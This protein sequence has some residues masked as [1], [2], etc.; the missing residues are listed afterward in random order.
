MLLISSSF[1]ETFA[2]PII[3]V[4]GLSDSFNALVKASISCC[5]KIPAQ[6]YFEL[7]IAECVDACSL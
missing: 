1:V 5:N 4:Y 2:P 6:A 7:V 3:A